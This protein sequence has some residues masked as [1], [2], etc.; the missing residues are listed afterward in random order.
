M[1][2]C[3]NCAWRSYIDRL[4]SRKKKLTGK[5]S[6]ASTHTHTHFLVIYTKRQQFPEPKRRANQSALDTTRSLVAQV[7][8]IGQNLRK[9]NLG[10]NLGIDRN[11]WWSATAGAQ[12]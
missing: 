8:K 12:S 3:N 5:K 11:Y 6:L 7:L 1:V 10:V 9:E 4:S 2:V